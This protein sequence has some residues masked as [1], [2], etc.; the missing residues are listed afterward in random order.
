MRSCAREGA[1][2][3]AVSIKLLNLELG[4]YGFLTEESM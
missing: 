3:S 1:Q 2:I 4:F